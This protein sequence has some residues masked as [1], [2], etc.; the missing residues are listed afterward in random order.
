M[1]L[2]ELQTNIAEII[3]G[4]DTLAKGGCKA[5]TESA[6]CCQSIQAILMSFRT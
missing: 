5:G 6:T 1:T 2:L 3:N 4:D